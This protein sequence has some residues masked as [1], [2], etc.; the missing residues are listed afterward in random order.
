[1]FFRAG[2]RGGTSAK[3]LKSRSAAAG[4]WLGYSHHG[5]SQYGLGG[6]KLLSFPFIYSCDGCD[7]GLACLSQ[8]QWQPVSSLGHGSAPRGVGSTSV[9][10]EQETSSGPGVG[11]AETLQ[12]AENGFSEAGEAGKGTWVEITGLG[13]AGADCPWP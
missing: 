4:G 5:V 2:R 6:R 1:M 13:R 9:L 12:Q 11:R 10:G 8:G 7:P 3:W